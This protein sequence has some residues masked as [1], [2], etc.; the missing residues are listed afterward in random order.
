M[1]SSAQ[2]PP[3]EEQIARW[4]EYLRRRPALNGRDVAELEDHLRDQ[5][6]GLTQAQL[7]T[8]CGDAST[9]LPTGMTIPTC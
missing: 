9:E 8:A 1:S 7:N 2:R 5:V 4:R 3:L 6:A